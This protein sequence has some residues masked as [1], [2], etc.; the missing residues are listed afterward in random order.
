MSRKAI[1]FGGALNP[2]TRA[3][4]Q[5]LQ[6]T[7]NFAKATNQEVWLLPS[8]SRTDKTITTTNELRLQYLECLILDVETYDVPIKI[9]T[10][11]LYREH[12][13]ETY[14]TVIELNEK[15]EEYNFTWVFGA[16]STETMNQWKKGTWL[17]EHLQMLLINRAGSKI[18]PNC[19]HYRTL[20]IETPDISSTLLRACLEAKQNYEYLVT[21]HVYKTLTL[22]FA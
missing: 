9:E 20:T 19:Q 1:I 3:H 8:G 11:E 16:D 13:V 10:M 18:N 22:A 4:A 15:Y 7:I 6:E 14:D 17:L 2:P 12:D 21:P 5:I